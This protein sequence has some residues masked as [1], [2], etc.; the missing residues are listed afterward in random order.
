MSGD[1]V[2]KKREELLKKIAEHK[3]LAKPILE[4]ARKSSPLEVVIMFDTT[5]SMDVYL[6][7][8]QV[9]V[10]LMVREIRKRIQDARIGIIV[11]KDHEQG[12]YVTKTLP[13][14]DQE[15]AVIGFLRSPEIEP[16]AGGGGAEAVECALY[17]ANRLDWSP[18][19]RG[20][21][22]I[23]IGDKPA[24][25]VM[26]GFEECSSNRD[27]RVETAN[28]MNKHVKIYTVLCNNVADT[29]NHFKYLADRTG[30]KFVT[31]ETIHDLVDLIVA[32]SIKE[33]NPLLLEAYTEEL[34]KKGTLTDSKKKLLL[35]I[36]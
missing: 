8:V 25:G 20:K 21:A 36:S 1:L 18:G 10:Q 24:H 13:L 19:T 32:V 26:D 22:I 12:P 35:G 23:L 9:H 29:I 6:N 3:A 11:Y 28:L 33:S 2:K 27:Y 34:N 31:L 15:D 16:G 14:T 4:K 30:G 17:E 5:G 7:E